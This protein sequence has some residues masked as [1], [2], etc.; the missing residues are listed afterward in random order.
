MAKQKT[1]CWTVRF[2]AVEAVGPRE[3]V[4]FFFFFFFAL[5]GRFGTGVLDLGIAFLLIS[6]VFLLVCGECLE[7]LCGC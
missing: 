6:N 2:A 7:N 3:V 5:V 1:Q 4:F